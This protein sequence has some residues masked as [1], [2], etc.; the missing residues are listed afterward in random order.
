MKVIKVIFR[1]LVIVAVVF[2]VP[3][4]LAYGMNWCIFKF[5]PGSNGDWFSFLGGYVG[6]IIT[7][8]GVY[9]QVRKQSIF[10]REQLKEQIS[11]SEKQLKKQLS[12]EKE[13]RFREARPLFLI[14][15]INEAYRSG[16]NIYGNP[17]KGMLPQRVISSNN[18]VYKVIKIKNI[19]KKLM[20]A[21]RI[22]I[23]WKNKDKDIVNISVIDSQKECIIVDRVSLKAMESDIR[24]SGNGVNIKEKNRESFEELECVNVY[25]C[26][27]L[28]EKIKLVFIN[29]NGILKY[30]SKHLENKDGNIKEYNLDDFHESLSVETI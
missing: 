27:E 20:S 30:H 21:V 17:E 11:N 22:E 6:A 10:D 24:S 18:L 12:V 25:F 3:I 26:T 5:V 28:R 15:I 2:G 23:I 8:G 4:L 19:S 14:S 13:D 29:D 1:A 16:R 7:I 9:W